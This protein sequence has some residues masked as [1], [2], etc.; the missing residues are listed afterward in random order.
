MAN[1]QAI[2]HQL[3]MSWRE[4]ERVIGEAF[5]L[6]GFTVTGFGGRG[7]GGGADLGLAKNGERFLVQCKHWR[8]LEVGVTVIREL[9]G[10]IAALGAHGGYV[11][12]GGYFTPQARDFADSCRIRLIDGAS[13]EGLIAGPLSYGPAL[14]N[15]TTKRSVLPSIGPLKL[16]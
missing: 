7:P 5:R 10:V 3:T 14:R 13:L 8:K 2:H 4:F 11:V 15:T 9:A 6:R 12:T 16:I 1:R